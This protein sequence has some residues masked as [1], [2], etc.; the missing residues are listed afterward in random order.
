MYIA[1]LKNMLSVQHDKIISNKITTLM[2]TYRK[3]IFLTQTIALD[4]VDDDECKPE[5]RE[6]T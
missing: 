5:V 3:C 4:T 2:L 1:A 6:G